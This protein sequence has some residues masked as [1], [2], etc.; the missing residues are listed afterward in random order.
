MKRVQ[1]AQSAGAGKSTSTK[2]LRLVGR[3]W[4]E[5]DGLIDRICDAMRYED[6]EIRIGLY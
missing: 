3:Q 4:C 6:A 1:K 5:M 2:K